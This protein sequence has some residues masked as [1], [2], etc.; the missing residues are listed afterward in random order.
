M[1]GLIFALLIATLALRVTYR[2]GRR[3]GYTDARLEIIETHLSATTSEPG[4][5]PQMRP[6]AL[7][8]STPP[9]PPGAVL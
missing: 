9:F 3:H 8:S 4:T 7:E 2:I 5:E 1:L 6:E